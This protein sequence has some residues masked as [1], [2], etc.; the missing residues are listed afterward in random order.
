M[1]ALENLGV[2]WKL[3]LAQAINFVVLL[4]ILRRYAYKPMLA[5]LEERSSRIEKGLKDA[6]AAQKKLKEM[7]EKEKETLAAARR[8]AKGILTAAEEAAKKHGEALI[9]KTE[10]QVKRTLAEAEKKISE[11]KDKL[12]SEA[13]A[14]IAEAVMLATEKVVRAKV[15]ATKDRELIET[16]IRS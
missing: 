10:M 9:A 1:E 8:E 11:E 13:K 4:F 15:D 5:F 12:L 3:F 7:E 16:A 2:D 6:E 14:Q